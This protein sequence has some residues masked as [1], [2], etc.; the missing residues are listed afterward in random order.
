[1]PRRRHVRAT[2]RGMGELPRLI[3][4][5]MIRTR[6]TGSGAT[7]AGMIRRVRLVG[8]TRVIPAG[9]RAAGRRPGSPVVGRRLCED[10]AERDRYSRQAGEQYFPPIDH[11][12][13]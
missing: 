9:R 10:R 2:H 5:R 4:A 11:A 12:R 3:T 6:I 8:R 1:V 7:G 13:S